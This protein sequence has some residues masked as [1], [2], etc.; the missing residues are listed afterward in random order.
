MSCACSLMIWIA[1]LY[2][3]VITLYPNVHICGETS[4]VVIIPEAL[5]ASPGVLTQDADL[6]FSQQDQMCDIYVPSCL[7]PLE[8]ET[9]WQFK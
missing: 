9:L 1:S 8:S 3:V 7:G 5:R 2:R 4:A 6:D